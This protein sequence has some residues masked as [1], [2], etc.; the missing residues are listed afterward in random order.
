MVDRDLTGGVDCRGPRAVPNAL[1]SETDVSGSTRLR[2]GSG[3]RFILPGGK[4]AS[5]ACVEPCDECVDG[6]SPTSPLGE[7]SPWSRV[8]VQLSSLS[9]LESACS[10][11]RL[12]RVVTMHQVNRALFLIGDYNTIF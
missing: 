2:D 5:N 11:S 10:F 8:P 9:R 4:R 1:V 7:R 3:L 6:S 12:A